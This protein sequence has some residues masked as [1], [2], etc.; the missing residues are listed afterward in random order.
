MG[1]RQILGNGFEA[2]LSYG[3]SYRTPNYDELYTYFVDSNHNVQGNPDLNSESGH[4]IEG[5]V[6]SSPILSRAYK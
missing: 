5:S 2:R 3:R 4:S 6:K 1:L